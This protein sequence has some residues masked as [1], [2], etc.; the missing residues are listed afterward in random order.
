MYNPLLENVADLKIEELENKISDLSKKYFI[1]VRYSGGG[2]AM[3]IAQTLEVYKN[4]LSARYKQTTII[5]TKSGE[6]G[7]DDLIKIN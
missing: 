5:P 7:L 6:T 4:E 2:I 1:A 3:Q